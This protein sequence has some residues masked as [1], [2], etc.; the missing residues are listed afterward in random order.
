MV[1]RLLQVVV[2]H[3]LILGAADLLQTPDVALLLETLAFTAQRVETFDP[4]EV[5]RVT[6]MEN[7]ATGNTLMA[8][9][10]ETAALLVGVE[11]ETADKSRLD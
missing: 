6:T 10:V 3:L 4:Q 5:H 7:L 9:D 1:A 8:V 2:A 11:G